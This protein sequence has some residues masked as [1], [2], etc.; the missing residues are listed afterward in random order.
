MEI[1]AKAVADSDGQ[2][3]RLYVANEGNS[4]QN[5]LIDHRFGARATVAGEK[6]TIDVET[7][8]LDEFCRTTN[9]EP[10][11]VKIDIEGAEMLA[12]RGCGG[13]LQERRA[14][15]IVAI[16]P[17]WLPEGQNAKQIFDLF[18]LHGYNLADSQTVEYEGADFGDYLFVPGR[19]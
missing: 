15:F 11:V 5:S 13:I 16:H 3:V 17:T 12:L 19:S 4:F 2:V 10:D 18:H 6:P 14:S 7:V 9:I 8:S 1:V